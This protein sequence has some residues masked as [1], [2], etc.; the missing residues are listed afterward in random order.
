MPYTQETGAAIRRL[1]AL[2][3]RTI[4]AMHGPSYRGDG[5]QVLRAYA[6]VLAETIGAA[7]GGPPEVD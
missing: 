1:A 7:T 6:V 2:A 5:A 4:A 3:P